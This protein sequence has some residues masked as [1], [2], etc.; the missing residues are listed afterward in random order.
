MFL[1]NGRVAGDKLTFFDILCSVALIVQVHLQQNRSDLALKEVQAAKRW[2]EDSL[3]VN[4][5]ESCVGMRVVRFFFVTM[6][7][8][9]QDFAN[10]FNS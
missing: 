8:Y 4:L 6:L 5:A 2:A 3:L 10:L 1:V 9:D 7:H